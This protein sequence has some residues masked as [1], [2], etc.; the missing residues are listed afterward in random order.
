MRLS[1]LVLLVLAVLTFA[2]TLHAEALERP[3]A[4]PFRIAPLGA[5]R[6]RV[7]SLDR[8][9]A[10]RDAGAPVHV[11]LRLRLAALDAQ[12][13]PEIASAFAPPPRDPGDPQVSR[14]ARIALEALGGAAAG[15]GGSLL[16]FAA[17]CAYGR[18]TGDDLWGI[19]CI[20][21]G[22]L[23]AIVVDAAVIAPGVY[24][25]GRGL[26]GQGGLGWTYLGEV[27]GG[28]V[29]ILLVALLSDTTDSGALGA[30]ISLLPLAGAVVGYE[31]SHDYYASRPGGW[32]ARRSTRLAS[33]RPAL[34]VAPTPHGA[35]AMLSGRF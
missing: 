19:G 22:A 17:G 25:V 15:L 24:L 18:S 21:Y 5:P 26:G 7:A 32:Q 33:R 4:S 16:G 27:S 31:L 14:G 6:L 1:R 30:V 8:G 34:H 13:G 23:G 3:A 9:Q 10:D 28:A 29:S 35:V 11:P 12:D 20:V 2:S